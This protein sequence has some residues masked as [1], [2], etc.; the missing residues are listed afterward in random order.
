MAKNAR[1]PGSEIVAPSPEG[2]GRTA[3]KARTAPRYSIGGSELLPRMTIPAGP[4]QHNIPA[5]PRR[6]RK[7]RP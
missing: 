4:S 5:A 3:R 6:E 7:E 1:S 2:K